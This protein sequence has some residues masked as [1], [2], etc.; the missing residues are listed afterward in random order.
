MHEQPLLQTTLIL[1]ELSG[2]KWTAHGGS[3]ATL[4]NSHSSPLSNYN[5][6]W[7][8]FTQ[9]PRSKL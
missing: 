3:T 8:R 2:R 4:L 1:F 7:S 6:M 9:R 5:V